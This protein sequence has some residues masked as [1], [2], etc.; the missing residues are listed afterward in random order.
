MKT[1]IYTDKNGRLIATI[2]SNGKQLIKR[3]KTPEQARQWFLLMET[4]H[5]EAAQLTF[6]QLTDAAN[7]LNLLPTGMTLTEAVTQWL[8]GQGAQ[9][10]ISKVT[11]KEAIAEY[12]ERSRSR[13]SKGTLHDYSLMLRHFEEDLGQDTLVDSLK[14]KDAMRYLDRYLPKPPTWH[15]YKRTLSKFYTECV[16]MEW[17][18]ENPFIGLDKPL[19]P[20]PS[21]TFLSVQDTET[22][23][24][25]IEKRA[26]RLIHFM[27]LGLFAGIRPIESLRLTS[28][29]INL[30]TGYIHLDAGITKS[31]SYK[32]RVVPI[33]ETLKAWFKAYPYEE[34]PIPVSDICYIDKVLKESAE[35]DHWSRTHDNL[36]HSFCTY[37]F[38][39][40][41]NSAETAMICGHSEAIEMKHYRGR[42]T[43]EEAQ[44]YFGI[45]PQVTA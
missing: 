24:R 3:V 9:S 2:H 1:H 13:I 7:A 39:L 29:N 32:E 28:S 14:K 18:S 16:K 6:K 25:S 20:P 34:K 17:A 40:T 33:N 11:L 4:Q 37:Q 21:R 12:L 35:K 23:L 44:R 30:N 27:T 36:R 5:T 42:V 31:H 8:K 38:A 43:K 41:G 26:P 10:S 45:L 15:A 19:L 22:A